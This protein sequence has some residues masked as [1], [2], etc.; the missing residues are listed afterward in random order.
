MDDDAFSLLM[1][2][3][4]AMMAQVAHW[5]AARSQK[6]A[7]SVPSVAVEGEAQE[8]DEGARPS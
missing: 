5:N 3:V 7:Q 2:R 8:G 1:G 4:N 6:N